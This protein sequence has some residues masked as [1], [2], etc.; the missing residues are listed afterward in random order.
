MAT[1]Q[2]YQLADALDA[3]ERIRAEVNAKFEGVRIDD[4]SAYMNARIAEYERLYAEE[5]ESAP[6]QTEDAEALIHRAH[7]VIM[8]GVPLAGEDK[9]FDD[10]RAVQCPECNHLYEKP[11][12]EAVSYCTA[13]GFCTHPRVEKKRHDFW[14]CTVCAAA[15]GAS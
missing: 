1:T 8:G 11:W 4:T 13:C 10:V 14:C 3:V 6:I 12:S 5:A 2:T 15:I 7:G 9:F